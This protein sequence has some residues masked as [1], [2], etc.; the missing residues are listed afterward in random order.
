MILHEEV[1]ININNRNITYYKNK[2]YD[3]KSGETLKVKEKDILP[4]SPLKEERKCDV[5]GQNFTRRR[6]NNIESFNRFGKDV[7]PHCFKTNKNIKNIVQ[8]KREKTFINNYG[9][10]NPMFIPELVDKIG[11]TLEEKYGARNPSQI[12]EFKIKQEESM[13]EK[14][15]ARKALQVKQFQEKFIKTISENYSVKTSSQQVA[16]FNMLK[17]RG[18]NV[19]LNYPYSTCSLDILII[20]PDGT[21]ID[22]EYDGS[23]WH[24]DEQ[25]KR[26]R[27]RDEFLKGHGFK[28]IRMES[29]RSIPSW[30]QIED[31]IN[32]LMEKPER[33]FS[34]LCIDN[35]N[36]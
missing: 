23:H 13:L 20:M 24:D 9:V 2:G 22:F 26:D 1:D 11:D 4:T 14:Y 18:Y 36:N 16:C 10:T 5:C 32:Y 25:K 33:K 15:G 30:E 31:E 12:E 8:Q 27:K 34:H 21:K 35:I 29:K 3:C 19:E 7:C 17:E 28:I 6:D